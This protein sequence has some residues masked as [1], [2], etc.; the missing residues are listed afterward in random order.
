M[1]WC[2]KCTQSCGE[3]CP[4]PEG[5]SNSEL[6]QTHTSPRLQG[7]TMSSKSSFVRKAVTSP[8]HHRPQYMTMTKSCRCITSLESVSGTSPKPPC[9]TSQLPSP[10]RPYRLYFS[11]VTTLHRGL[12]GLSGWFPEPPM[13]R[14]HPSQGPEAEAHLTLPRGLRF[15]CS[16]R[17]ARSCSSASAISSSMAE[18]SSLARR[19]FS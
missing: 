2:L 4:S 17:R 8:A 9:G 10:I 16:C 19:R 7:S 12:L 13:D 5:G 3:P 6:Q 1:S 15:S 18:A 11:W 14:L